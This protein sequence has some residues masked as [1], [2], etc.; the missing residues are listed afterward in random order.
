[1]SLC[2]SHTRK[3]VAGSLVNQDINCFKGY[4]ICKQLVMKNRNMGDD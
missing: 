3:N 2:E 1:M 4:L